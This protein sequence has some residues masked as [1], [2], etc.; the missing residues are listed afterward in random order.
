MRL[1]L[2]L[3]IALLA[4][5]AV[6]G[7]LPKSGTL[8]AE[9]ERPFRAE[10][11][12]LERL[13]ETATDKATV[14]YALARTSAA[15]QQWP[16]AMQWLRRLDPRSG[17]DPSK[18]R[19]FAGLRGTVEFEEVVKSIREAITP[20]ANSR[21]AFRVA[22]GDLAPESVAYDPDAKMFYF[23]SLRKGK[24]VRCSP[25]GACGDFLTGMGTILGLKVHG[26]N[27][28]LL[29]NS[30]QESDVMI[31]ELHT[32]R[33]VG[34]H[35]VGAGHL[36]NDLVISPSGEAFFTDTR[37]GAVWHLAPGAQELGML[38]GRFE[39]ANGIAISSDAK[40]LYVSSFPDGVTVFDLRTHTASALQRPAGLCL[41]NVDGLY[42]YRGDLI[43]IQ[44]G[45]MA[46]RVIRI[47]LARDEKSA[48]R[49]DVLER[50]NPLFDGVT[51]GVVVGKSFYF[52]ANI[53]DDRTTDF[54][55]IS[56][57]ALR[58]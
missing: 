58:L 17:I 10:L 38:P 30:D 18:D 26:R 13:L 35:A 48:V 14:D 11:S 21:Q 24:V 34:K 29:N 5:T 45:I 54:R 6:Y 20:V 36:L 39:F 22:E 37:A 44:N 53:Q 9:D 43:A 1:N 31:Y 33:I 4:G 32:G 25:G 42:F 8:S 55:P 23:G 46:T 3:R 57:L 16:E 50:G 41:A 15:G 12:R 19:I 47:V 52:M 2:A 28:W 40:W 51:T 49:F 56:V 27:L 7:Q